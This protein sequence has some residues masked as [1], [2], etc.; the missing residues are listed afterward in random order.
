MLWVLG[1]RGESAHDVGGMVTRER[2]HPPARKE[3]A[4][5]K[6]SVHL[7]GCL[8]RDDQSTIGELR[9]GRVRGWGRGEGWMGGKGGR[10]Q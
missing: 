3:Y 2:P 5:E 1:V 9:K 7:R 6:R 8:S 10:M 4:F